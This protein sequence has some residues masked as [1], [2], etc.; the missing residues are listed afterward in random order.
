MLQTAF[1]TA[2][3]LLS[4]FISQNSPMVAWTSVITP[5]AGN[6]LSL[7]VLK[8]VFISTFNYTL[9][10]PLMQKFIGK[11]TKKQSKNMLRINL[12]SNVGSLKFRAYGRDGRLSFWGSIIFQSVS[13]VAFLTRV[14]QAAVATT[15]AIHLRSDEARGWSQMVFGTSSEP[16][17]F[18]RSL[19]QRQG[20]TFNHYQLKN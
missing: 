9:I 5:C 8:Y 4:D 16:S 7:T 17:D 2:N 19:A 11:K 12:F 14:L 15:M 20:W 1:P 13:T 18:Q 3:N 10:K 6:N